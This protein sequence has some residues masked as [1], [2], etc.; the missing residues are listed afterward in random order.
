MSSDKTNPIKAVPQY[1]IHVGD[2]GGVEKLVR[3]LL[4][5]GTG[6]S[7]HPL[8]GHGGGAA[9]VNGLEKEVKDEDIFV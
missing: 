5:G 2:G 6:R 3:D 9:L 8:H 7:V 1:L 4:D